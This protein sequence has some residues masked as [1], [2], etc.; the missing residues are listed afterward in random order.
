MENLSRQERDAVAKERWKFIIE[1][2]RFLDKPL[3]FLS[4]IWV[5]LILVDVNAAL[6]PLLTFFAYFIWGIFF[7]DFFIEILVA[8]VKIRYL[9]DNWI[10]AIS[11]LLPILSL[12]RIPRIMRTLTI[13]RSL[14]SMNLV[15]FLAATRN[16]LNSLRKIMGRYGLGYVIASTILI[17]LLGAAGMSYFESPK[18]VRDVGLGGGLATYGDAL[19]WTAMML[20]T[21]GTDYWPKTIEGRIL[22]WFLAI[23]AFSFFSYI[24]ANIAG[25]FVSLPRNSRILK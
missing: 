7:A 9:K 22:S 23:Y 24:T 5:F 11:V 15:R 20:T 4:L 10:T 17:C 14:R 16:S 21:M 19:W 1:L 3:V 25:H 12:L 13:L 18:A 6:P 2:N 8:P